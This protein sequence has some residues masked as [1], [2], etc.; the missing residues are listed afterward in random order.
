MIENSAAGATASRAVT[1][2]TRLRN[3]CLCILDLV[4]YR[5]PDSAAP[6]SFEIHAVQLESVSL[7]CKAVHHLREG[8]SNVELRG[9]SRGAYSSIL[10]LVAAIEEAQIDVLRPFVMPIV[11]CQLNG[12][13]VIAKDKGRLL[14]YPDEVL[15]YLPHTYNFL[16]CTGERDDLSFGG[17]QGY[18]LLH[19]ASIV[20]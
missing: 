14:V 16:Y 6:C 18:A 20:D 10:L 19:R 9:H 7:D 13:I 3:I 8:V 15:V 5:L 1:G 2:C 17:R 4:K 11:S 12:R